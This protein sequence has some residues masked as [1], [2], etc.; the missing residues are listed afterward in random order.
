MTLQRAAVAGFPI[1]HSQSPLL[2]GAAYAA[3]G[4]E[5]DYTRLEVPEEDAASLAQ[6]LRTEPGWRGLSCTMPLKAALV[7]HMDVVS[8][9]VASLGVL[10]TIIVER[11]HGRVSLRGENTDVDG[12]IGALQLGADAPRNRL[13]VLGG[14]GTAAATVAAAA[15]LGFAQLDVVVRNTARATEARALAD[16]LGMDCEALGID[17]ALERASDYDAVVSTLPPHAADAWAGPLSTAGVRPGTPLLDVAY[18]PWPSQLARDW[19]S[20]GGTVVDGLAM[21]VYQAVEQALLFAR[22]DATDREAVTNVMCDAVG[23][24]RRLF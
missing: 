5:I 17:D 15:Q 21:L 22:A 24:P 16:R 9:R 23:L 7:P 11:E 4:V 2:H 10:N 8:E 13:A 20:A 14:G 19:A 18:D 3:L 1:S 12:I 6:R